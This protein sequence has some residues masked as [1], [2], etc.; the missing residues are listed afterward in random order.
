MLENVGE[1]VKAE[2]ITSLTTLV[3]VIN[4]QVFQMALM[5]LTEH[6]TL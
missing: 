1:S 6:R 3:S 2:R 4:T 5:A